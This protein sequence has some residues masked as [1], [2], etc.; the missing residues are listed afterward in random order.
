L[1]LFERSEIEEWSKTFYI[2]VYGIN[3][4]DYVVSA[5]VES[6]KTAAKVVT[7]YNGVPQK[8]VLL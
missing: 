2:A 4:A 6:V 3:N 7:L 5:I 1:I 8:I